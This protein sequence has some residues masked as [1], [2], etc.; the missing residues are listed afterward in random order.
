MS[1]RPSEKTVFRRNRYKA[2]V[3]AEEGRRR[4]EDHL[5]EIRKNKREES[6][7]KK[8]R[9]GMQALQDFTP[10]SAAS[11]EN[12]LDNLAMV[13]GI[14]SD[15]PLLQLESATQ[16]R[17]VL[18]TE[19]PPIDKVVQCGVVPRFVEFLKNDDFPKLQFEASWVLTNI[20]SGTLEN[21]MVVIDNGAVPIFVHLLAS[22]DDALREQV[23]WALGNIAGDATQCRDLVLECGALMP[24]LAQLNEHSTS[25]MVRNATWTLSNFCRGKPQPPFDQ[26]KPTIPAFERLVHSNDEEILADA[27]WGLSFLADGP[28][29][30][31]QCVV[32]SGVVPRL[33]QLLS[34]PSQCVVTPALRTIG[35]I[36]TGNTQLTQCVISYG[37]LPIIANLLTQN[38]KTS[39]KKEA[40]WTISNITAGTVEQIQSV[41]DANLIPTLVHLAQCSV[42]DIKKEALWAISNAI[43]IGSHDQIKYLVEQSCIKPLCDILACQDLEIISVCLEGLENILKV[44]EAEKITGHVNFAQLI[45]DAEGVEKIENLQSS[46]NNDIYEKAVKILETYWDE[47]EDEETQQQQQ[48]SPREGGSHLGF[49]FGENTIPVS[50]GGFN[51]G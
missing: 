1:L 27:C 46:D 28:D 31:I 9:D 18:S 14:W 30:K 11:L 50:P 5:V 41:I 4:R 24:L 6:L 10:E 8:R 40:C 34:H 12:M 22:P 33:V 13:T 16:F 26:V 38:Y 42:F 44:G 47:E 43:S 7:M 32:E 45:E 2:T 37:A 25:S 35:N 51:F 48:Q 17:T 3:D 29:E 19:S 21:T 23:V 49:H 39:T 36:V 15:D 20:V